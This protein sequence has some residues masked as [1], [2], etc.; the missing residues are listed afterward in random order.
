VDALIAFPQLRLVAG[1]PIQCV[2]A[3]FGE[4]LLQHGQALRRAADNQSRAQPLQRLVQ[5][6]KR[7]VQPPL[8][9]RAWG[10]FALLFGRVDKDG[11]NRAA[12]RRRIQCRIICDA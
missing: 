3:R 2:R 11:Y 8:T 5:R 6:L 7:V 1:V 10:A 9:R 4:D 12:L